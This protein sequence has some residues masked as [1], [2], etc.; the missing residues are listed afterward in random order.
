MNKSLWTELNNHQAEQATGG[1][2][3]NVT[4]IDSNGNQVRLVDN[5][6]AARDVVQALGFKNL[7]EFD[8]LNFGSNVGQIVSTVI[9]TGVPPTPPQ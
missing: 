6:L 9:Q 8:R 5:F 7:N 2:L 3:G 4:F 1:G